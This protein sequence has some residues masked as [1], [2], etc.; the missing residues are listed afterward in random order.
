L[1]TYDHRVRLHKENP[2]KYF[3]VALLALALGALAARAIWFKEPE[4]IDPLQIIVTQLKTHAIVEHERQVAIWYRTCPDVVGIDPQIFIAWPA[5][6][7]YE[8]ELSDVKVEREGAKIKVHTSAIHADEPAVPTDFIDYLS[9]DSFFNFA[10]EDQIVN[11]EIGKASAI[12]RYLS[13]YFMK[14][15]QSLRGD[16]EQEVQSLVERIASALGVQATS[17]E[18]DVPEVKVD[19][20]KLPNLELCT[21]SYA[22]V[23]GLP[24][25]RLEGKY[26]IPIGFKPVPSVRQQNHIS[27]DAIGKPQGI[28]SVYGKEP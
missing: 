27:A 5:K 17:V 10:N 22:S 13:A 24:F 26:T 20:P 18:V 6:L 8:L 14:R 3:L 28:A 16:F 7:S 4:P 21:G 23:N 25:A 15:D 9:T 11:G 1:A 12:A 19:F 2:M